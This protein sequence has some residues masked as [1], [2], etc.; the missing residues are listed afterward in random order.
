MTTPILSEA[1]IESKRQSRNAYHK[2]RAEEYRQIID[3]SVANTG[4]YPI[5]RKLLRRI[6]SKIVLSTTTFYNGSACWEWQGSRHQT[7]Y[8]SFNIVTGIHQPAHR[9]IY[10]MFV[11]VVPP[12]LQCD[13]LC[14][15]K[16]CV[17]PAHLEAVTPHINVIRGSGRVKTHCKNGH[18]FAENNLIWLTNTRSGYPQ[19]ICRRC[20]NIWR[21][22]YRDA[23]K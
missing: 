23:K 7:G 16:H 2:R 4:R 10:Q 5:T 17:N 9:F 12:G 20:R 1:D 15:V 19:R 22:K 3:C 14:R 6:F 11:G 13:H 21:K 18:A 8:G